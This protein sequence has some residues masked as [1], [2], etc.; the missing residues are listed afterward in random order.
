MDKVTSP[1]AET[2]FRV[3][4]AETDQMGIVHHASYVVWL[5]EG[6]SHFMRAQGC[7]YTEFE[8]E[9]LSLAV[10]ELSIRYGLAAHYDQRV[11]VRCRVEAV[12]SRQIT[13]CYEIIDAET[14]AIFAHASS[15]HVC[16]DRQGRVAQIPEKWRQLWQ[17][18]GELEF[19]G[20][21]AV[22]H[23]LHDYNRLPS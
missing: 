23:G 6:R 8:R 4:Y 19:L 1:V 10:S 16:V 22:K 5:E 13:F 3:R 20:G 7:S 11:T 15:S 14:G 21:P 9:G 12:K 18:R 2:T 17:K